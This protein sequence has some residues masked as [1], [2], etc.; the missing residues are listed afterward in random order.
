MAGWI[1]Q[2]RIPTEVSRMPGECWNCGRWLSGGDLLE[3]YCWDCKAC[4]RSKDGGY[5]GDVD[6]D[7]DQSGDSHE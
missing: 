2:N 5:P 4:V 1:Q 3:G 6:T 7:T